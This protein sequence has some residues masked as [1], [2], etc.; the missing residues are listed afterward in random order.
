MRSCAP[1]LCLWDHMFCPVG[2]WAKCPCATELEISGHT[3]WD[4]K[5]CARR[6]GVRDGLAVAFFTAKREVRGSN[7]GQGRNL[8]R[9]IC[10]MRSCAPLLC[11]WDHMSVDIRANPKIGTHL[12]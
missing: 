6:P 1:L 3:R 7:P 5:Y 2:V 8:D 9:D 4:S 11:L 12:K 10:S